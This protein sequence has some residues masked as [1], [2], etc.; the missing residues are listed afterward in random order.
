M[1][2]VRFGWRKDIPDSRDLI[3]SNK[4]SNLPSSCY[5]TTYMPEVFDQKS[6][7]SCSGN[8]TT[9]AYK[10]ALQVAGF[11]IAWTPSRIFPYYNGRVLDGDKI[12]T[13]NGSAIRNVIKGINKFGMVPEELCPFNLKYIN[14]KPNEQVYNEAK[15]HVSLKY[16]SVKQDIDVFKSLIVSGNIFVFGFSCFDYLDSDEMNRTGLLKMPS[17]DDVSTGG[18]ATVC[19]GYSDDKKCFILRNSWGSSFALSGNFWMPMSYIE[20]PK[21]AADFWTIEAVSG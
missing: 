6:S 11:D 16:Q 14:D 15:K 5:N 13:D 19:F 17:S 1:K 9:T 10:Y 8:A 18:H 3:Y 12:I 20:D 2:S 21:L 4:I 7:N